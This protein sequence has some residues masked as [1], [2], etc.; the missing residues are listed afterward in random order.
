MHIEFQLPTGTI[1]SF[2]CTLT[3]LI[4]R[5]ALQNKHHHHPHF[6]DRKAKACGVK[7]LAQAYSA[8][9]SGARI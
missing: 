6:I 5:T 9:K 8:G 4:L 1:L 3:P 7:K 2:S